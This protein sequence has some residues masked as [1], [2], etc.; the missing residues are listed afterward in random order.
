MANTQVFKAPMNKIEVHP[1]YIAC[2]VLG[3][4]DVKIPVNQISSVRKNWAGFV[5]VETAGGKTYK[6]SLGKHAK[7]C[8]EAVETALYGD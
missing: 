8:V 3:Q 7:A 6:V 5:E 2:R 4:F 1:K